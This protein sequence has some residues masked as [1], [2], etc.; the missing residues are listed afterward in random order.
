[1][2]EQWPEG[3]F[4]H[5]HPVPRLGMSGAVSPLPIRFPNLLREKNLTLFCHYVSVE[6]YSLYRSQIC[7]FDIVGRWRHLSVVLRSIEQV[8]CAEAVDRCH[9]V[10]GTAWGVGT[11]F[12]AFSEILISFSVRVIRDW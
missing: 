4:D 3:E 10:A 12:G 2:F 8:Q 5:S 1:M 7:L 11:E 9:Y 6:T